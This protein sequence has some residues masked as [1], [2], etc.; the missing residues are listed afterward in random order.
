MNYSELELGPEALESLQRSLKENRDKIDYRN[1]LF[2]YEVSG[3]RMRIFRIEANFVNRFSSKGWLVGL[4]NE[5]EK[6][7]SNKDKKFMGRVLEAIQHISNSPITPR[8]DTVKPLSG[9]YKGLWRYRLGDYRLIYEPNL[10]KELV[11]ILTVASRG[12]IYD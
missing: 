10:E 9:Q 6:S 11:L 8:G 12:G 3:D 7:I 4:T 5:F 1:A 2:A